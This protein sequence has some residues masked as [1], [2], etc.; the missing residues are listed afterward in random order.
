MRW[1]TLGAV[2]RF[3]LALETA[4]CTVSAVGNRV[5]SD[6]ECL[7][8]ALHETGV[9]CLIKV[10]PKLARETVR[11]VGWGTSLASGVT[12]QAFFTNLDCCTKRTSVFADWIRGVEFLWGVTR[13]ADTR[14][15]TAGST[16]GW[17]IDTLRVL[18]YSYF[19]GT[20]IKAFIHVEQSLRANGQ[21]SVT[22]CC[23]LWTCST[24]R[25]TR[26]TELSC[27]ILI[28]NTCSTFA[29]ASVSR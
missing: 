6:R 2:I 14:Q 13:G 25:L 15:S 11:L 17:A 5:F 29:H 16:V 9:L 10:K 21:A 18:C 4:F 7:V 22:D 28:L 26:L 27:F 3:I 23:W 19:S 24:W 12:G 20:Y 1:V 8:G